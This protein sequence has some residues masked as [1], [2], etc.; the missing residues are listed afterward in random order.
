MIRS[1]HMK[2][3][4]PLKYVLYFLKGRGP[5]KNFFK[6]AEMLTN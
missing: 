5:L 4:L 3:C 6:S 1:E 2:S